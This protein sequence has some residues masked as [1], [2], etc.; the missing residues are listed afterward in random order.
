VSS[1]QTVAGRI[2]ESSGRMA[3]RFSLL[4]YSENTFDGANDV[5]LPTKIGV[6]VF[7]QL[8]WDAQWLGAKLKY[9]IESCSMSYE[10]GKWL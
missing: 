6:P 10:S 2:V 7:A 5:K 4:F 3:D 8:T 9:Y 1:K